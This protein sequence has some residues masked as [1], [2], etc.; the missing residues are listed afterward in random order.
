MLLQGEMD[1]SPV[2]VDPDIFG[3][4]FRAGGLLVKENNVRL[5]TGFIE[6]AGG[7]TENG[8]QIG[9]V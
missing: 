8:M 7:Q 9:G 4:H 6:D 2:I 1:I 3:L 5:D